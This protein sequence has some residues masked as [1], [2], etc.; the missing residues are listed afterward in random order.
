MIGEVLTTM[1][2]L[3]NYHRG[4]WHGVSVRFLNFIM[5]IMVGKALKWEKVNYFIN[6]TFIG[7]QFYYLAGVDS[8]LY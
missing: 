7:S 8:N 6:K 1:V 4:D 5:S 2:I 3:I